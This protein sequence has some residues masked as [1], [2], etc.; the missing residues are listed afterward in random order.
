MHGLFSMLILIFTVN[1]KASDV[2][3]AE[4]HTFPKTRFG[5][6]SFV[7]LRHVPRHVEDGSLSFAMSVSVEERPHI[8]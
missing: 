8:L 1:L 2:R 6:R 4:K 3:Q 5:R 7:P